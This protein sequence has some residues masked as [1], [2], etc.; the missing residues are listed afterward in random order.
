V[1]DEYLAAVE[2]YRDRYL[3]APIAPSPELRKVLDDL[4][5]MARAL[6]HRLHTE[7]TQVTLPQW[8][9]PKGLKYKTAYRWFKEGMIPGSY[10]E[11]GRLFV[12]NDGF[13]ADQLQAPPP[14]VQEEGRG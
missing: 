4:L 13:S 11:C 14:R 6:R 5:A 1:F 3:S 7:P 8:A 9:E 10:V 2:R 12:R